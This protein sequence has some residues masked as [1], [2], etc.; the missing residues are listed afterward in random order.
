MRSPVCFGADGRFL[1]CRRGH[2]DLAVQISVSTLDHR[3]L[4]E[5]SNTIGVAA[6]DCEIPQQRSQR[7]MDRTD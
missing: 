1:R 2:G 6:T 5:Y 3:F 4:A 7:G